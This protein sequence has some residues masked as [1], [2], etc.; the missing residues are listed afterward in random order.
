[1]CVYNRR[2]GSGV[3]Q[4]IVWIHATSTC[5]SIV[6]ARLVPGDDLDYDDAWSEFWLRR[7]RVGE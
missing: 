4:E 7:G 6:L 1:M 2:V 3:P 5:F